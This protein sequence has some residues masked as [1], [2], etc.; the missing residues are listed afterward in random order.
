MLNRAVY[1]SE[2]PFSSNESD[3]HTTSIM[4]EAEQDADLKS[5]GERRALTR[6]KKPCP[7]EDMLRR[8]FLKLEDVAIIRASWLRCNYDC[9]VSIDRPPTL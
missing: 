9:I 5:R 1:I 6:K 3:F 8:E 2:L 7:V 4:T